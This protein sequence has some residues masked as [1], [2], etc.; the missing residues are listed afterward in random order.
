MLTVVTRIKFINQEV[1]KSVVLLC[2]SIL[3]CERSGSAYTKKDLG[4]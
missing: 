1:D 4:E 3:S 2:S